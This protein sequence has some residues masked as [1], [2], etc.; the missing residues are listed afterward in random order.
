M[1]EFLPQTIAILGRQPALGLAELESLYGPD[2]VRPVGKT[3][4]IIDTDAAEVDFRRLGGTIKVARLL[5]EIPGSHWSDIESFLIEK[6]PH[7]LTFV[8]EGKFTLGLSVYDMPTTAASI[9]KTNLRLKKLVR[10]TGRSMRVVPNKTPELNSAQVLHNRLTHKG[11]WELLIIGNGRNTI[12][13]QTLFVQDIDAYAGRDQKRPKRDSRVGMLPPK[14][15]QII[16]NLA[17]GETSTDSISLID[18]FCGTGVILQ[19]AM[20]SGLTV[21][22]SDIDERMVD[23]SRQNIK[24]LSQQYPNLPGKLANLLVA[25]VRSTDWKQKFT[26][27][28]SETYLGNPFTS[29]PSEA[30]L[31]RISDEVDELL[32]AALLNLKNQLKPGS[33][34]CLAVPAW[35]VKKGRFLHLPLLDRLP[36]IGYNRLSFKNVKDRDLIYYRHDQ[37]VARELVVL[38]VD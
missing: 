33:R 29:V 7:H 27:V 3:A 20:L 34:L 37:F 15:A 13:A 9:N 16:I 12:L 30:A 2:Q 19:E 35:Q 14:L 17:A 10:E 28:A 21:T 23:Y 38:T 22:G 11:A 6:I 4:A 25:D 1:S 8:P 24:W 18:P 26:N 31:K 36:Q 5:S 32:R